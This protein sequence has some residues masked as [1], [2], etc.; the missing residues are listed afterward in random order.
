MNAPAPA[1]VEPQLSPE[2]FLAR[3]RAAEARSEYY[4][5]EVVAMAGASERHNLL[6]TNLVRLLGNQLQ[7]GPCRIYASDMRVWNPAQQ[8]YTFPDV[9]VV[10]GER[11]FAD[12]QRDV[13]LNPTL[14][15]EVLSPSTERK[16]R[17]KKAEGFRQ[18][19]SLQEYLFV[20]Q[21]AA[22]VERYRRYSAR[23]WMLE[24]TTQDDAIEL[25]PAGCTLALQEL[26]AGVFEE[27]EPG[28]P[29]GT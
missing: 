6:V 17:G 16:D 4:A 20:S 25:A 2:A 23:Q 5:G 22:H 19:A 13:L 3:D 10:C 12:E 29:S 14:V 11:R 18:L 8:S 24:E 26:Y 9:V 15:V 1:T 7:G 27:E 28:N 21:E